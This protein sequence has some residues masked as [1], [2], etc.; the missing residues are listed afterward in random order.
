MHFLN[1]L[2][3]ACNK[4][5]SLSH[6]KK[7]KKFNIYYSKV[8]SLASQLSSTS[9]H[10]LFAPFYLFFLCNIDVARCNLGLKEGEVK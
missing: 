1:C 10:I 7:K 8:Y 5:K 4:L 2:D 9:P 6:K 3:R